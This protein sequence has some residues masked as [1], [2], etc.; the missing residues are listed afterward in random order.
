MREFGAQAGRKKKEED[1]RKK[2]NR[3]KDFFFSYFWSTWPVKTHLGQPEPA[4]HLDQTAW[5]RLLD[6][7]W[8]I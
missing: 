7:S 1:E 4:W 6:A 3:V 2:K 5:M 8:I